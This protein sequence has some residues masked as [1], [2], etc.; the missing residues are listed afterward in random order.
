[1][2]VTA[3]HQESATELL[4]SFV[5]VMDRNEMTVDRK[6]KLKLRVESESFN[7]DGGTIIINSGEL[8]KKIYDDLKS[9]YPDLY[10]LY[11]AN[12][13]GEYRYVLLVDTNETKTASDPAATIVDG[14]FLMSESLN[15]YLGDGFKKKGSISTLKEICTGLDLDINIKPIGSLDLMEVLRSIYGTDNIHCN[16]TEIS[17]FEYLIFVN[18]IKT[19]FYSKDII[20]EIENKGSAI[21]V[22]DNFIYNL[23]HKLW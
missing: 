15:N 9:I 17:D 8:G 22:D 6:E 4:N 7:P 2:N 5:D 10:G 11:F 13:M 23:W 16:I 14:E 20:E 21:Y 19:P 18:Y 1:M 3:E 12:Y